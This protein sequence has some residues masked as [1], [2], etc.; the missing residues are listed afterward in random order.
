MLKRICRWF[1]RLWH[2]GRSNLTVA[3]QI[4]ITATAS[5][6]V[7]NGQPSW[8]MRADVG[9]TGVIFTAPDT[10][11]FPKGNPHYDLTFTLEDKTNLRLSWVA[12][13]SEAIWIGDAGVTGCPTQG[14]GSRGGMKQPVMMNGNL[15]VTNTNI[16]KGSFQYMLRFMNGNDHSV[17][18]YDPIIH[19]G[20]GG[21]PFEHIDEE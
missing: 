10:L 15:Q 6:P 12:P 19:N 2:G 20:G 14:N 13:A 5:N 16:N 1:H 3:K 9:K 11:T 8:T 4:G 7:T 21:S 17:V 18:P